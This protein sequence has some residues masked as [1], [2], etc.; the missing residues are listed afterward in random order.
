MIPRNARTWQRVW[1]YL[2][3]YLLIAGGIWVVGLCAW[4]Y[5]VDDA[6]I[7]ARYALRISRGEGYTWNPG[8]ASD[9]VTGPAWL[10]PGL[11][12][13]ALGRDPVFAAKLCGLVCAA[14]AGVWCVREQ[15]ARSRGL[16]AAALLAPLL[17][18]QPSLGGLGSAGLETGAA[19]LLIC[20]AT[21]AALRLPRPRVVTLGLCAAALAW[22]RP[23]LAPVVGL[24]LIRVSVRAGLSRSLWA[25]GLALAGVGTVC[26]LRLAL[27]G[28]L[29]PLAWYAKAGGLVDGLHYSARAVPI[30]TGVGGLALAGAGAWLGQG[31]DRMRAALLGVHVLSV[32][33]AGGDWMPGFRLF[34]PLFPQYALLAAVGAERLLR[35]SLARRLCA[36]AALL[37]ACGVPLVDLGLRLPQWRASAASRDNVGVAIASHLRHEFKRVALVDIGFIGYASGVEVVDLAGLTD[38]AVA[39]MPGGHLDK[40]IPLAWLRE[41]APDALILHSSTPPLAAGDGRL[42]DLR[43]YPVE[44]RIAR[45]EWVAT[46]FR[47]VRSYA[48]A[49]GY[50]YA[51]L[52]RIAP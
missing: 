19:T 31:R 35:R 41:R 6:Y 26:A 48:Y 20:V 34:V 36:L 15:V 4:P 29:L 16:R 24:L 12:A 37:L 7:I 52:R 14:L 39:A 42:L 30:M 27:H 13:A 43:G 25:W 28:A 8:Q 45:S 3:L 1:L 23:E 44:M 22:L 17:I 11:L 21:S 5:T 9:G 51:L 49:P 2:L 33:L 50:H 18:F 10:L 46:E 40:R 38:P 47:L 32:I